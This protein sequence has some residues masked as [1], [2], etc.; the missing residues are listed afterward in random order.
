[1]RV[2]IYISLCLWG[3]SSFAQSD[4]VLVV[5]KNFKFED[6]IYLNFEAFQRNIPD[7]TWDQLEATL[8]SNPQTYMAQVAELRILAIDEPIAR[9]SAID[10]QKIWG[11]TIGGIPY[12]R[13][14]QGM[15]KKQLTTFAALRVRGR[16][17]Y[18]AFE[19]TQKRMIPM[20][21]YNPATGRP[22]HV[23]QVEREAPVQVERML[24]FETGKQADFNRSNFIQ[25][26]Q[27]DP[28]LVKTIEEL[29][30]EE[31][32]QKLFKCL[33]IYDDRHEVRIRVNTIK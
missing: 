27:D 2:L 30:P 8:F 22:F 21:I 12:I 16:I 11:L 31:V 24:H 25:W 15:V 13:L 6:G 1:M 26:I 17:C 28:K 7:Y 23:A 9:A 29:S 10:V 14:E 18:Y 33:L 4:S 32:R 19:E 20:P 3:A 5:S